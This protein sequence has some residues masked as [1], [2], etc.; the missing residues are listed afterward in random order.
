MP[1]IQELLT[2]GEWFDRD[3]AAVHR[4]ANISG[5]VILGAGT[6][7]DAFVTLTGKVVIGR[8][9]HISTGA[10]VFGGAGFTMDDCSGISPGAKVFTATEDIDRGVMHPTVPGERFPKSAPIRIGRFCAVGANS[11]LLPGADLADGVVIGA[12]SKMSKP[13][14]AWSVW[15][16]DPARF[17]RYRQLEARE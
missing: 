5:G 9:C 2:T 13:A 12:L 1:G 15:A 14:A 8:N 3:G 16:G 6:R 17:L 11:V 7:V 10:C 4:L